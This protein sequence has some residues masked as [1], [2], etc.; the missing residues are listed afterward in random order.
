MPSPEDDQV[1]LRFNVPRWVA[2]VIDA[3][4]SAKRLPRTAVAANVVANWAKSEIHLATVVGRVTR[5]N[6]NVTPSAWGDL[7]DDSR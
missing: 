3:H 1:E 6:G 2:E 5:G 4:V 7:P